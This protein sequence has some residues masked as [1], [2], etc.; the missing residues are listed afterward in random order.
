[1]KD[2]VLFLYKLITE[3]LII[4]SVT[5]IFIVINGIFIGDLVKEYSSMFRLGSEGISSETVLQ[6]LLSST[7]VSLINQIFFSE[8]ILKKMMTLWKS[9]IMI[10]SIIL[11]IIIFI[12]CFNW[13]PINMI[14]A[15]IGFLV[16]FGAFVLASMAIMI[17]KTKRE[18]KKYDELLEKYKSKHSKGEDDYENN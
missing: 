8:K 9:I 17:V 7:V 18:A 10:I 11:T 4:F 3:I 13:F 14:E 2:K 6:I 5:I 15:W 12:I 16:S 1:M